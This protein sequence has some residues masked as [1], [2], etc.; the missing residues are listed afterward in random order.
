MKDEELK[1]LRKKL[2][3]LRQKLANN[4]NRMQT[5][6][7]R[8]GGETLNELPDLP[9]EQ[10]ADQGSD[11]FAKDLMIGILQNSEAEVCE[12]DAAL[13]K[14]ESGVYGVCEGC[15]SP[16]DRARLAALPFARLC[17]KCKQAEESNSRG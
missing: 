6:A 4:V 14:I 3:E 5:E 17:M 8:V 7:L 16:I 15:K 1:A 2:I 13:Q 9:M 11:N 12:I 10:L